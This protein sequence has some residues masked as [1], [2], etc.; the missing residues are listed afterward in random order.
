MSFEVRILIGDEHDGIDYQLPVIP[1]IGETI[2]LY[3]RDDGENGN[4]KVIGVLYHVGSSNGDDDLAFV[5]LHVEAA[6]KAS[7][8]EKHGVRRV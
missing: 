8:Y 3:N 4:H 1:R 6:K 7:V 5:S 2:A